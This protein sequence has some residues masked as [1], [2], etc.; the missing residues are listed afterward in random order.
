MRRKED[1]NRSKANLKKKQT[2]L[3]YNIYYAKLK[4]QWR[5]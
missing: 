2:D 4:I 3:K 1:I 5:H